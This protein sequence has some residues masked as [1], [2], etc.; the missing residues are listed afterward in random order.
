MFFNIV[1]CHPDDKWRVCNFKG[2][3]KHLAVEAP[4]EELAVKKVEDAGLTV[5]TNCSIYMVDPA[6]PRIDEIIYW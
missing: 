4:C 6:D 1:T 5:Q 2:V 3:H